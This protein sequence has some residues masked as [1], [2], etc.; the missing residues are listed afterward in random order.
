[1]ERF[2]IK[3]GSRKRRI[4]LSSAV[5]LASGSALAGTVTLT[6]T[7]VSAPSFLMSNCSPGPGS[8]TPDFIDNSDPSIVRLQP[9]ECGL[10]KTGTPSFS[11]VA[12]PDR[13]STPQYFLW[14]NKAGTN[15]AVLT[16]LPLS[17]PWVNLNAQLPNGKLDAGTYYWSAAY[18]N[19]QGKTVISRV[20]YFQIPSGSETIVLP[21]GAQVAATVGAKAFPRALPSNVTFAAIGARAQASADYKNAYAGLMTDVS[22]VLAG[23][24]P[25]PAPNTLPS[26]G[27]LRN[28]LITERRLIEEL[29]LAGRFT[30]NS[31]YM[32]NGINR[33]MSLAQ[34]SPSGMTS[35]SADDQSNREIL[36]AL[37]EGVDLYHSDPTGLFSL[38]N[39]QINTI[40][41]PLKA[42]FLSILNGPNQTIASFDGWP[43]DS[44]MLTDIMYLNQALMHVGGMPGFPESSTYL[45][46]AWEY[47]L[48]TLNTF[49]TEDGGYA[50]GVAY[51][52]YNLGAL[53]YSM[54]AVRVIGGVD[55]SSQPSIARAGRFL[56]ATTPA[57]IFQMS[58]FGDG[59]EVSNQYQQG[60]VDAFKLY[61]ALNNDPAYE[62]YWRVSPQNTSLKYYPGIWHFMTLGMN[63]GAPIARPTP[64][65]P[66]NMSW[67]FENTG[68]VAMHNPNSSTDLTT[69]TSDT[70][71]SS[72]YFRS[73]R[74]GSF[75]HSQADQNAFELVSNGQN[76]L[77][78]GGYYP[79]YD[80]AHFKTD[81]RATRYKNA[82]TF[83]GGIGQA[84]PTPTPTAPGAPVS[85][86]YTRGKL[87][88]MYDSAT[89]W[90]V[91][92][93][94][95]TDAYRGTDGNGNWQPLLSKV[96]RTVA[97]DRKDKVVVIYDYATSDTPRTWELNF[98]SMAQF[99]VNVNMANTQ[100]ANGTVSA[101]VDMYDPVGGSFVASQGFDI[102]P[103]STFPD[104]TY[105][106]QY[107]ARYSPKLKMTQF[108]AVTI[109]R[110]G[111][112]S[113]GRSATFDGTKATATINGGAPIVFDKETVVVP[114]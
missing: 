30:S 37:A 35:Q 25:I 17:H 67:L 88:N 31:T 33:L 23:K 114:N 80:A 14:L 75:N 110:E 109:I 49:T 64:A 43:N 111:C 71:R 19:S 50:N 77:I 63:N 112:Q 32:R 72:V 8:G 96:I 41:V 108:V 74:F 47:Y 52:W 95:A 82:L 40:L 54:A 76:V 11:W 81:T 100:S 83:D 55:V 105:R 5:L 21:T 106:Q 7:G 53:S 61:S 91:T 59:T 13:A 101:C 98:Q 44:H 20:R 97:Y 4:A 70:N 45:T 51:G 60:T 2:G 92:T 24:Y 102:N 1:L 65:A 29:A 58:P 66:T 79:S 27:S 56:I 46:T 86:M 107:H 113:M 84:E 10:V 6:G 28:M 15:E 87:I 103:S 48:N 85:T 38:N 78:S 90:V 36:L 12:P 3:M 26:K 34:W 9:R 57:N 68:A 62:W 39:N 104:A 18:V 89:N 42:R 99:N 73:G 22:D 69:A 16:K 94:D 93:G